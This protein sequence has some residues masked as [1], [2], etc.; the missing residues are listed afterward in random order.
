MSLGAF[1]AS[2]RAVAAA[3]LVMIA[4]MLVS[5]NIV[6]ARFLTSRLDLTVERLYTLSSG[7]RHTLA[8]IDEPI[9]LR[10]IIRRASATR[11]RLASMPSGCASCSIN[12]SQQRTAKSA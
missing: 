12:M 6:A 11:F 4:V 9:T 2:R 5:A 3:A 10:F 7:T 8:R 1:L